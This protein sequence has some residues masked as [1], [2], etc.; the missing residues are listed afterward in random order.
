MKSPVFRA[1]MAQTIGAQ[2]HRFANTHAGKTGQQEGL[3]EQI[4]ASA[5]PGLQ[6]GVILGRQWPGQSL[7]GARDVLAQQQIRPGRR[8]LIRQQI[9]ELAEME[10][11]CATGLAGQGSGG[12]V[13]AAHP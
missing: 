6:A 12:R 5:Q 3:G 8:S 10:Q 11:V 2:I 7:I 13:R 4:V 9:E 1:G